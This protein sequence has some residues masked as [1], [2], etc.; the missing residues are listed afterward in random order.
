MYTKY[1]C[2]CINIYHEGMGVISVSKSSRLMTGILCVLFLLTWG[3]VWPLVV[4]F[5]TLKTGSEIQ[6]SLLVSLRE[7]YPDHS[8]EKF[9]L[10]KGHEPGIPSFGIKILSHLDH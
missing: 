10:G 4:I 9:A 3:I 1:S 7:R 8:F 5:M 2:F 6:E